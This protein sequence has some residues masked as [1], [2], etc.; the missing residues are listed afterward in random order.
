MK[1]VLCLL[2]CLMLTAAV[3]P[4]SAVEYS[5]VEK[6]QRQIDFGNGLKGTLTLSFDGDA[7]WLQLIAPLNGVTWQI[8]SIQDKN[9][10]NVFQ[11]QIY[12]LNGEEQVGLTQLYGDG[13]NAPYGT[14]TYGPDA[15]T[16][17]Y[18]VSLDGEVVL[19]RLTFMDDVLQEMQLLNQ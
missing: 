17:T 7:E 2:L 6:L 8:R 4:A 16:V 19:L 1:K 10:P 15:D 5:L 11:R 9:D 14:V 18:A 13:Q 3:L 12:T